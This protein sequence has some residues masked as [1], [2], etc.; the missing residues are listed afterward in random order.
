MYEEVHRLSWALLRFERARNRYVEV[1]R[2]QFD[3]EEAWIPLTEALCWAVS[4]NE[5]LEEGVGEGYR[6][7]SKED[8]DSQHML[9][10]IFARNRGGHQRALT[11][12][13][14]DGLSFPI[15]FPLP[16]ARIV[17][18]PADEIRQ[19]RRN[20]YSAR[21]QG[22]RVDQSLESVRR[23]FMR[24]HERWPSELTNVTWP[25]G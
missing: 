1:Q 12:A 22:N 16:F 19:G 11:I 8:E 20:E 5:G 2:E 4:V 21:L 6:E 14:A 13:V 23:W 18:R 7:A 24:A 17:W 9:G 15:S 25:S 3:P 10:L